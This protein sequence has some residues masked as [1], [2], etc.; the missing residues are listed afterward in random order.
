MTSLRNPAMPPLHPTTCRDDVLAYHLLSLDRCFPRLS[1]KQ[2]SDYIRGALLVGRTA[3]LPYKG[4]WP[5][6]VA[7]QLGVTIIESN[8][9]LGGCG[10]YAR[11][12]Y[13]SGA[14][15]ITLYWVSIREIQRLLEQTCD[16]AALLPLDNP[17]S[18][19]RELHIAH[20][21]FH[22]IEATEIGRT[23]DLLPHLPVRQFGPL[24][25]GPRRVSQC[26]EIAA[27]RFAADLL[28]LPFLPI[29]LDIL[30]SDLPRHP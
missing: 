1:A 23:D 8:Q 24:R 20:E 15:T 27:H 7:Q 25:L 29:A 12:E 30:A 10:A 21:L 11:S 18:A 2:C 9:S 19:A 3:A 6:R 26:R 14:R 16:G 4:A 17:G 13:D 28:R 5:S 22:H